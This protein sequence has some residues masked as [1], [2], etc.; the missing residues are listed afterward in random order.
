MRTGGS[1]DSCVLFPPSWLS[2]GD[3]RKDLGEPSSSL[4]PG[5]V[6]GA[7]VKCTL[8]WKMYYIIWRCPGYRG[9]AA[10]TSTQIFVNRL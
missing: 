3:Q 1:G 2:F 10:R 5:A 7:D 9:P 4:R 8:L 6:R